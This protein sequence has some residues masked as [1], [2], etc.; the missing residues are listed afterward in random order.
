MA[1]QD[2][3]LFRMDDKKLRKKVI[4]EDPAMPEVI[5]MG[6]AEEQV[7]RVV[8]RFKTKP[9]MD[10]PPSRIAALEEQIRALAKSGE[11]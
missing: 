2:T 6:I 11:K 3:I 5:K 7:V 9:A 8:N 10:D 1:A 4:A